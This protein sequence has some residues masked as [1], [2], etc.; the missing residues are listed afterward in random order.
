MSDFP[1]LSTFKKRFYGE[2][3]DVYYSLVSCINFHPVIREQEF[4]PYYD[5]KH[6]CSPLKTKSTAAEI[7]SLGGNS[8]QVNKR[9]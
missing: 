4:V 7:S 8:E 6:S 5:F 9:K 2:R 1:F 3:K